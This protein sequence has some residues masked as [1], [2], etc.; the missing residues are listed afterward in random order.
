MP[1]LRGCASVR[2]FIVCTVIVV[3]FFTLETMMVSAAECSLVSCLVIAGA[4]LHNEAVSYVVKPLGLVS[5]GFCQHVLVA[6]RGSFR[7]LGGA[8]VAAK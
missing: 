5:V 7:K 4:L 6:L 2:A 1:F 8:A 3:D